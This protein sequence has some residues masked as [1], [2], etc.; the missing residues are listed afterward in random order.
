[1]SFRRGIQQFLDDMDP[2]IL[3]RGEDY[4]HSGQVES[5]DWDENHVTAEVSGSEEA[6]YLVEI[7]FSEDGEV[8]DWSCDCPTNGDQCAS[9]RRWYCW[10]SN[11]NRRRGLRKGPKLPK[12]TF[13]PCW[14]ELKSRSLPH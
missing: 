8:E 10:P 6:P 7:D 13:G 12:L 9:T 4:Y 11:R 14:K 3:S 5:I 2:T 1:M